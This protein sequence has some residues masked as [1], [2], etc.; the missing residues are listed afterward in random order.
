MDVSCE[1]PIYVVMARKNGRKCLRISQPIDVQIRNARH[2][3]WVV[4]DDDHRLT[5][6]LGKL[7]I[8]PSQGLCA[9]FAVM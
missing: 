1:N 8:K 5:A 2:E 3:R 7:G 4:H 9:Q 6:M